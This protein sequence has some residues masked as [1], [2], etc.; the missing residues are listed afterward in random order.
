MLCMRGCRKFCQRGYNVLGGVFVCFFSLM[1]GG[2]SCEDFL[3]DEVK[4]PC[5]PHKEYVLRKFNNK[6]TQTGKA[7]TNKKVPD[8]PPPR[9]AQSDHGL[10]C[11]LLSFII[12]F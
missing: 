8:Q 7:C 10:F 6:I 3:Q 5:D 12:Y 1:R 9:V 4:A 11:L 2:E